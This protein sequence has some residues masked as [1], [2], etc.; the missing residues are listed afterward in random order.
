TTPLAIYNPNPF[1]PAGT[2]ATTGLEGD[3][4][5]RAN[6]L[7]AG[8]PVNFFRANPEV[9]AANVESNSGYTKYDSLQIDVTKRMSHGFLAQGSYVYGNA[10]QST[11]Y[12]LRTPRKET[13]QTGAPGGITHALKANWGYE[14]PFGSGHA[15]FSGS[16]GWADRVINGW[17][18]DGVVRIQSGQMQDFG[19]VR[20]VG[21]SV[22]DLQKAFGLYEY[23]A[24]GINPTAVSNIYNLPKDILENTVRA[25]STSVTSVSGYASL[26]APTGRYIAPASG[27]SCIE[28][29][30]GYGDC[31]TRTLVVTGPM[32][33]RWDLSAVKRTRVVGHTMFE[34]R[35][36][37]INAFNHPNFIPVV[38]NFGPSP[39]NATNPTNPDNYRV[40]TVQ[41]NSNRT[42]QLVFRFTW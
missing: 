25:F 11:R 6:A 21:M 35:A 37:M 1:T 42:I 27:P 22:K 39:S 26:G 30:S 19:N 14:L 34:F 41:E 24:T 40:T 28:T 17:E 13:L 33:Q 2:G 23:A 31:G 16:K 9:A 4:T 8:I 20:L 5:R 32:Y 7:A 15:F 38:A 18:F 29:V 3:P 10:Y 36:D 12:S